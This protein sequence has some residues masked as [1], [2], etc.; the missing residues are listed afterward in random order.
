VAVVFLFYRSFEIGVIQDLHHRRG[1]I[2]EGV[3]KGHWLRWAREPG[4]TTLP[5]CQQWDALCLP[6]REEAEPW[7]VPL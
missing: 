4:S 1:E 3:A 2:R 5:N 6:S 7:L